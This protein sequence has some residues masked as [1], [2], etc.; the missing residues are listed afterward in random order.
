MRF[1]LLISSTV[2]ISFKGLVDTITDLR[3]DVRQYWFLKYSRS[4]DKELCSSGFEHVFQVC[5]NISYLKMIF[6]DVF[7]FKYATKQA[8]FIKGMLYK[9]YLYGRTRFF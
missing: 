1:T 5:Y 9:S 3:N 4:D 6:C 8:V 7:F 2:N